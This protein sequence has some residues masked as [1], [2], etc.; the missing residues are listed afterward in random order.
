VTLVLFWGRFA[1]QLVGFHAAA[2]GAVGV[3]A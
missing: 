3:L 2:E 1:R